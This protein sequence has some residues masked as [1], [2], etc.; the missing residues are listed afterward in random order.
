[1]AASSSIWEATQVWLVQGVIRYRRVDRLA[2]RLAGFLEGR[3]TTAQGWGCVARD[4]SLQEGS[5]EFET[6]CHKSDR[7][8]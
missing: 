7:T 3:R 8:V 4:G 2:E 1:M 6:D 5:R